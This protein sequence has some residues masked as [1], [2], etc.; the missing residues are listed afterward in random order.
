MIISCFH[1]RVS[2]VFVFST[3]CGELAMV[4]GIVMVSWRA[5][6]NLLLVILIRST[7]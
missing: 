2:L 4:L 6:G 3:I 7:A 1:C 5:T